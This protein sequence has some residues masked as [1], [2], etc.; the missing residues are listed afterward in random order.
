[1]AFFALSLALGLLLALRFKVFVLLPASL[2]LL[3]VASAG[4]LSDTLAFWARILTVVLGVTALQ[5]G[6]FLGLLARS[7]LFGGDPPRKATAPDAD[8]LPIKSAPE[9]AH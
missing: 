7:I 5:L 9:S 3:I 8:E 6:Y 4:G 1:M 2:L